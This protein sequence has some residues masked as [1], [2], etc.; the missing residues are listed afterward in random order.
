MPAQGPFVLDTVL[1]KVASRC[2]LNCS[3]CYVYNMGDEAWRAQPKRMSAATGARIAEQLGEVYRA[4]QTPFS[5]V[6]HGGEPL[7]IGANR[8]AE[9]LTMLRAKLPQACGLH[10]QT[11]GLL[12]NAEIIDI[13][14]AFD[15]GIS[16]SV[17]GPAETHDQFRVDHRGRP[18]HAK[19]A[20]AIDRLQAR[21]D[22]RPLFAGVLAVIDPRSDPVAVYADLKAYGAPGIDVLVRDGNWDNLPFGKAAPE[23]LEYG[24]WL[25]GLLDAYLAD[26]NPPRVRLLD[27][28]LR[29][30]LGG[31]GQ[32]EGVGLSDYGILVIEPDGEVQKND[33]LKVAHAGADRFDTTWNVHTDRLIS[34]LASEGYEAYHAQQRPTAR[35]CV[36]CPDLTVCGGGMVAH[37]WREGS[38]YANPTVFCAD[39]KHL[40]AAMRRA[41]ARLSPVEPKSTAA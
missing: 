14:V 5:V 22:A 19:V 11:N 17:D 38:R 27:D 26:S 4:Q 12:L 20:E 32:K 2:N 29:L 13:L 34:I 36:T 7:L 39:Q 8:L 28:M 37:R 41:V 16:I 15:V 1:L 30:L 40:I 10:V 35:A 25:C 18:S 31:R 9:L 24:R 33:T 3:Y 23:T 6:L 21:A